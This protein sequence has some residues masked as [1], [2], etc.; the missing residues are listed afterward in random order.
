MSSNKNQHFVPRHYL[1]RFCFDRDENNEGTRTR[2]LMIKDGTYIPKAGIKG[3]CAKPYFYHTDPGFENILTELEGK[4]EEYFKK[5]TDERW[6]PSDGPTKNDLLTVL[7]IMRSRT[8][9][10]ADQTVK[11]PETAALEGFR[12]YLEANDKHEFLE[13][14]PDLRIRFRNWPVQGVL[15]GLTNVTLLSDLQIKLLSAPSGIHFLTSDHP[16]VMLNQAFV[17]VIRNRSVSGLAMR[18]LQLFL[19]L[20]PD[21]LMLAFDPICYRVGQP[22][23][24]LIQIN[25]REDV[26]LINALQ[27]LNGNQCLY[28]RDEEDEPEFRNLLFKFRNRR[29][30]PE[31]LIEKREIK[32]SGKKGL[33][34]ITH[35]PTVPLPGIWSFCKIR[36]QVSSRDF[37]VRDPNTCR[38]HEESMKE[39]REH[40]AFIPFAK[41]LRKKGYLS[42]ES[43]SSK[44]S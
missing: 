20:S 7:N 21:L 33:Y 9:M 26:E 31:N 2:I 1:R 18:G 30:N 17:N 35:A 29:P 4:A 25:R 38:L 11:L 3:Q 34:I 39:C 42:G 19:P 10:F 15:M 12:T 41:W 40:G 16:V 14:L 6:L 23:R 8:E 24:K 28:F 36:R 5:I 32:E 44:Q 13:S 43:A 22:N 27:V 37:V